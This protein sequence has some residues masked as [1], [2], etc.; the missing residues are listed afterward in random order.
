MT[1]SSANER[2]RFIVCFTRE[3]YFKAS[4]YVKLVQLKFDQRC[5][6]ELDF[7]GQFSQIVRYYILYSLLVNWVIKLNLCKSNRLW[8]IRRTDEIDWA[9]RIRLSEI[10]RTTATFS[11]LKVKFKTATWHQSIPVWFE[12]TTEHSIYRWSSLNHHPS[13][14]QQVVVSSLNS[15]RS[16]LP[17]WRSEVYQSPVSSTKCI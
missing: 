13:G 3:L 11:H 4:R 16:G 17:Y 9:V 8:N 2:S 1:L 5:K 15:V 6:L 12:L 14:A 7:N 10:Q